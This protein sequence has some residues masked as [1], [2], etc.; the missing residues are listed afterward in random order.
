MSSGP[1][2]G[3]PSQ[4]PTL[5]S[6]KSAEVITTTEPEAVEDTAARAKNSTPSK[7]ELGVATP[8]R[9]GTPR[10]PGAPAPVTKAD[11]AE[12]RRAAATERGRQ[13]TAM[14]NG[15][16]WALMQRDKGPERKLVRDVVDA[17]RNL[18]EYGMYAVIAFVIMSMVSAKNPSAALV[19]EMLLLL[20]VAFVIVDS[21]FLSRRIKKIVSAKMPKANL[22]GLSRYGIAR[23]MQFRKMRIP[24]PQV[25]RGHKF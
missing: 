20:M 9:T 10:R 18:A 11:K 7:R 2:V 5:F 3:Y 15:E 16:E 25:E 14:M 21:F 17:R 22:R 19:L 4:V 8:K 13:R 6:R 24:N 1:A 23:S 12:A